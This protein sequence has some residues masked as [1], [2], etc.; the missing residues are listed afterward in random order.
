LSEAP[1]YQDLEIVTL[2]DSLAYWVEKA[3]ADDPVVKPFLHGKSPQQR[4]SELIRGSKLG[5][6]CQDVVP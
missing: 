6:M 3:G 2:A 4:A 1:L 5:V